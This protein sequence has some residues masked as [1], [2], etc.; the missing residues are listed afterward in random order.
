[1]GRCSTAAGR[2]GAEGPAAPEGRN[3]RGRRAGRRGTAAAGRAG[4]GEAAGAT[5]SERRSH[6]GRPHGRGSE[7][8]E[9]KDGEY[10]GWVKLATA[11]TR[12]PSRAR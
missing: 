10:D 8:R 2:E 6:W 11:G 1:V 3:R 12:I 7:Q 4:K 5:A 9:E